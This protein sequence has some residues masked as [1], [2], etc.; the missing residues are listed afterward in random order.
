MTGAGIDP[1]GPQVK[2]CTF[3]A[4]VT[5]VDAYPHLTPAEF[6]TANVRADNDYVLQG[7]YEDAGSKHVAIPDAVRTRLFEI[8]IKQYCSVSTEGLT[9][10]RD[11]FGPVLRLR[12]PETDYLHL[13]ACEFHVPH[14]FG[15]SYSM[16]II[17]NSRTDE[18][19][20]EPIKMYSRWIRKWD[21]HPLVGFEDLDMDGRSEVVVQ[22]D[23]HYGTSAG[24]TFYRYF[25]VAEDLSF[26]LVAVRETHVP[27]AT[28]CLGSEWSS[29]LRD[30]EVIEP[31]RITLVVNAVDTEGKLPTKE[32]GW[33]LFE[34]AGPGKPFVARKRHV[35]DKRGRTY[36]NDLFTFAEGF[37]AF[38]W[39]AN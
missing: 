4:N 19:S 11:S 23:C 22:G 8:T 6:E 25:H 30:F 17:H 24:S 37:E 7:P 16:L 31:N 9:G 34:C 27:C 14:Y 2:S 28:G 12:V 10:Y 35:L 21:D 32:V 1:E 29:I 13:Y 15:S 26:V 39:R 36:I 38:N 33:V 18:V 5:L 3:R 20:A